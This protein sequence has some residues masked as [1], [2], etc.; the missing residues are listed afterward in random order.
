MTWT[1]DTGSFTNPTGGLISSFSS[2][3]LEASSTSSR[4]SAHP[5]A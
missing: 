5:V 4:T 1:D 2:Y 3:G